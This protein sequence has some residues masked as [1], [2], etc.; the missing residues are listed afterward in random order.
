MLWLPSGFREE[1]V[2]KL[3]ELSSTV[4]AVLQEWHDDQTLDSLGDKTWIE[5]SEERTRFVYGTA[6]HWKSVGKKKKKREE[7]LVEGSLSVVER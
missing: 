5:K 4:Y 6:K 1:D 3:Y 2:V 7:I